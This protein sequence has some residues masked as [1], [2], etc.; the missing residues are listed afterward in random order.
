[1]D[2]HTEDHYS[3]SSSGPES[4][5]VEKAK[6]DSP[7]TALAPRSLFPSDVEPGY[8]CK[9]E[10]VA[11]H[12]DEVEFKKLA[13]KEDAKKDAPERMPMSEPDDGDDYA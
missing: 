12:S 9:I 13:H 1:M 3:D 4:T 6:D 5:R 10:V 11:V 7:K 8:Q 2:T